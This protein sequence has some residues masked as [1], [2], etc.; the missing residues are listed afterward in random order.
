[1]ESIDR[2]IRKAWAA[3]G[4]FACNQGFLYAVFYLG[5]H[6]GLTFD[7][8]AYGQAELAGILLCMVACFGVIYFVKPKVRNALLSPRFAWGYAAL[9]VIC[10]LAPALSLDF[11]LLP[12]AFEALFVGVPLALLLCAWG[13]ILGSFSVERAVPT[14]FISTALASAI[15]LAFAS[16]PFD[17][18]Y[19]VL[20]LLPL[21]SASFL[22]ESYRDMEGSILPDVSVQDDANQETKILSK[23]VMLGTFSYGLAIGVLETFSPGTGAQGASSFAVTFFLLAMFCL[24]ALQL[25]K[26]VRIARVREFFGNEDAGPLDAS[27]RLAFL[28]MVAGLLFMPV[29]N[30]FGYLGE[31]VALSGY[32]SMTIVLVALFV[33][34]GRVRGHDTALSF[35]AGFAF[36]YAGEIAGLAAGAFLHLDVLGDLHSSLVIGFAGLVVLYAYLFL[37]TDRD[38]NELSVAVGE[39]SSFDQACQRMAEE[40][41]LSKREAE[42][43]PL[44]LRG[45]TSE[46]IAQEFYISKNT[47]DTHMRRIYAKCSVSSRQ[48]LIDLGERYQKEAR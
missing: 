44:A 13:R 46:R 21:G 40:F 20:Y 48:E 19:L 32:L 3:I 39:G 33:I 42:I 35:A 1:M 6:A 37:F 14:L 28:V 8:S 27:Y 2:D 47:V 18:A 26:G 31:S 17:W 25:F 41:G 23:K 5:S 45:R 24:A 34:M 16:L 4:G 43:L 29:L 38:V 11:G 15:C 7:L 36:L 30:S 10:S 9:L 12:F 22:R